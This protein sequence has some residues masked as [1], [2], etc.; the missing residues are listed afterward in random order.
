MSQ[1]EGNNS[2]DNLGGSHKEAEESAQV[3]AILQSRSRFTLFI[4]WLALFLTAVGIA[5]GYKNWMQIND[6]AKQAAVG[7]SEL[8]QRAETFAKKSSVVAFNTQLLTDLEKKSKQLDHSVQTLNRV[9]KLTQHAI[10]TVEQQAV[11]L[12]QQQEQ[13][14]ALASA[15]S[16]AWRLAELHFLLQIANQRLQL[17]K[18]KDGALQAL[19]SAETT[20]LKLGSKKYLPVRKKL[21]EEIISVEIFLIPNISAISQRIAELLEVINAMPV[22]AEI[23]KLQ[24][25]TLLPEVSEEESGFIS[26]LVS[27]I[28]N[29]VVIQKFDPSVRKII[30]IDEKEKLKN[31]LQLRFETLRLMVLQG[32][33]YDYHQQLKLIQQMLEKYYPDIIKGSLEQQ[34]DELSKVK[35]SPPPPDISGS[36]TLLNQLSKSGK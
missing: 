7:V 32:L 5:A 22:E 4:A 36:L 20:L 21:A 25:I 24:K 10:K 9:N 11:L 34:L 16:Y 18:D 2:P 19:R 17:H 13:S 28:N 1:M 8:K 33:D 27:G 23:A 29:A 35:L 15:P 31:L 12:T 6:R 30:G 14:Q 3:L 26:R